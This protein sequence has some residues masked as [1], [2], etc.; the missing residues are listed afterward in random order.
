[1]IIGTPL[2]Y[3]NRFNDVDPSCLWFAYFHYHEVKPKISS[4]VPKNFGMYTFAKFETTTC[5]NFTILCLGVS[6]YSVL[7]CLNFCSQVPKI[8]PCMW[9]PLPWSSVPWSATAMPL[10]D[11]VY[12]GH[13][14]TTQWILARH[15]GTPLEKLSWYCPTLECH[16]R[17]SDYCSLHWNTTG[18]TV[19][20]HT[21]PGTYS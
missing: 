19:T 13:H 7:L 10:V 17:N 20:A 11:P 4:W 3:I 12:T 16:W 21:H 5:R 2:V 6:V 14:W 1:M 8:W 15:N 18:G 9:C